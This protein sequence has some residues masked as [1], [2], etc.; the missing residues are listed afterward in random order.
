MRRTIRGGQVRLKGLSQSGSF[1]SGNP[2][3][4]YRTTG[5]RVPMPDAPKDSARFLKAYTAA[6][7]GSADTPVRRHRSGTIAAAIDAFLAS[8]VYQTRAAST[9]GSWRPKLRDISKKYGQGRTVDLR[10]RHIRAD[11]ANFQPHPANNRLK[12][13]RA[14]ARFCVDAG[15]IETDFARDVRRRATPTSTGHAPWTGEDVKKFR[16]RWP[17]ESQQRL[18]MELMLHTGAAIGD[19]VRL[20]PCHV[21]GDWLEYRRQKSGTQ[22]VVPWRNCPAW[23]GESPDLF[24]ALDAAPRHMTFLTRRG[25]A[26]RS[27]KAARQ[28]FARAARDAGLTGKT[29]HGLRK[30]RSIIMIEAGATIDQRMAILGHDTTAQSREYSKNADQRRIISGTNFSNF[31]IKLEK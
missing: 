4:Y 7:D 16:R 20:G 5:L 6:R 31:P 27:A 28:W 3:Y 9:R 15:L 18:A 29:A 1:P 12:V 25:A 11:L 8:D 30:L 14:F 22:A 19:A 23:F 17:I 26:A 2:R 13:W 21:K 10:A 24:A